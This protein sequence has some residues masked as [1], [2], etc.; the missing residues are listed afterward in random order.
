MPIEGAGESL[1]STV[2]SPIQVH[3]IKKV[4]ARRAPA[5]GEHSEEVL[6]QL[7]FNA[8]EIHA[9]GSSGVVAG[10]TAGAPVA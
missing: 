9:L 4:P 6:E 5:I 8:E 2:S 1:T 3:G 10:I 7:G